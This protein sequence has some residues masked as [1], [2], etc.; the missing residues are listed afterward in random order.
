MSS[1][2]GRKYSSD[3]LTDLSLFNF[4]MIYTITELQDADEYA[5]FNNARMNGDASCAKQVALQKYHRDDRI[6][7]F[8]YM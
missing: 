4:G 5:D 8:C 6:N 1:G 3:V 7:D 2:C